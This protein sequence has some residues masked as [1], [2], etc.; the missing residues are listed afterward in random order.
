MVMC[1]YTDTQKGMQKC[2]CALMCKSIYISIMYMYITCV[3]IYIYV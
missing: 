3:Y 2:V 1:G